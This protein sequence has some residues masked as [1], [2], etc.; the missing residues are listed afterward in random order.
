MSD[1]GYRLGGAFF[2]CKNLFEFVKAGAIFRRKHA[3]STVEIAEVLDVFTD[4]YSIPH[5]RFE[6]T[7]SRPGREPYDSGSRTMAL[8]T[9]YQYYAE[10]P[11][12]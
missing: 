4:P 6:F 1:R 8:K 2:R 5:V 12:R 11:S 3:Y 7:L 9:F 10:R